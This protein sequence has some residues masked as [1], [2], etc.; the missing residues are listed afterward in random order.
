MAQ[1]KMFYYRFVCVIAL[2]AIVMMTACGQKT[3]PEKPCRHR[4]HSSDGDA[5]SAV[6]QVVHYRSEGA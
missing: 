5:D 3:E 1:K 2:T 4:H 6:F